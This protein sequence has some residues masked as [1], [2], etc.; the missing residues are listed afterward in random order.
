[1]IVDRFS[2]F[3]AICKATGHKIITTVELKHAEKKEIE[4]L[5][6]RK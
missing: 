1:M 6:E 3:G 2:I 5:S 4:S